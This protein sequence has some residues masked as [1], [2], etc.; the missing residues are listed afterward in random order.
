[1]PSDRGHV[2]AYASVRFFAEDLDPFDVT[3][4]LRLPPDRMHRK[5]EPRLARSKA[6]RVIEYAPYPVGMWSMSSKQ[7]VD[8]PKLSA[9]VEWVLAELEPKTDAVRALTSSAI[10]SDIFCYSFGKTEEPPTLPASLHERASALGL[11][12]EIDHY[13]A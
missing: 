13:S 5:G 10:E 6:G 1:M 7:W 8:S 4:Q 12:I 2:A 9:H 3:E 11:S